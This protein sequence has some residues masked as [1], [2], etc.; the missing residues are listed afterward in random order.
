M[1]SWRCRARPKVNKSGKPRSGPRHPKRT[2][3]PRYESFEYCDG[4]Y[5]PLTDATAVQMTKMS[6]RDETKLGTPYFNLMHNSDMYGQIVAYYRAKNM[7]PPSTRALR[8]RYRSRSGRAR[9]ILSENSREES[10]A[11][12]APSHQPGRDFES[13]YFLDFAFSVVCPMILTW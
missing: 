7:V 9:G 4:A 1:C 12:C 13:A 6:G 10:G 3:S 11:T 5:E 8:P 2:W